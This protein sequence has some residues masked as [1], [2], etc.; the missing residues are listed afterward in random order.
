MKL[1]FALSAYIHNLEDEGSSS[2][3]LATVGYRLRPFVEEHS[4]M[5]VIDVSARRLQKYFRR[6]RDGRADATMAGYAST[7]RA[8]WSWCVGEGLITESPAANLKHWSYGPVRR[9]AAPEQDIITV[10][11]SL[12]RFVSN[13]H[14]RNLRDALTVSMAID[15]GGRIGELRSLKKNELRAALIRPAHGSAG[16]DA[17]MVVG[18][19][20]TGDAPLMFF[21][22]TADLARLWL[23]IDPQPVSVWVFYNLRNGELLRGPSLS[24]AFA[25]VCDFAGV[26]TFRSHALRKRNVTNIISATGNVKMGQMYAGHKS[27]QTTLL[28]YNDIAEEQVIAAA[29]QVA[30]RRRQATNGDQLAARFFGIDTHN[31]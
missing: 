27:S 13:G 15:C 6:L 8:F 21:N 1:K 7:H 31:P 5:D 16:R 14:P 3:H 2:A 4:D 10:A 9:R 28:H 25:R 17:Y 30:A 20:K 26:P 18:V 24:R 11:A 29:S 23:E 22:E 19:G 12:S